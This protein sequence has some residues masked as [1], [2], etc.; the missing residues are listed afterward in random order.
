[1]D[2]HLGVLLERQT[3]KRGETMSAGNGSNIETRK[4][5]GRITFAT[6]LAGVALLASTV[7]G[8]ATNPG[9][10][11]YSQ[12]AASPSVGRVLDREISTVEK[13]A[14]D[15]AEAMPAD[16]YDFSP[17]SLNIPGSKYD[18]VR[19]FGELVKHLATANYVIWGP[20]AGE[21]P[22]SSI[23]GPNGPAAMK[24]K[25][26]IVQFLKD[27]FAVGHRAASALN[28][29]NLF[30]PTKIQGAPAPRL[31]AA[32]LPI[33]HSEDMYGQIVEYLRMNGIVPPASVTG[34]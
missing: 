17:R 15:A 10:P 31:Y 5:S 2:P 26:E 16:K 12:A 19:T 8:Q 13:D 33:W 34:P 11:T 29:E 24:S 6:L 18:D 20:I 21:K 1:M 7:H 23:T 4:S 9:S 3:E 30:E 28:T 22:P 25:A 14:I 32:T 27:S